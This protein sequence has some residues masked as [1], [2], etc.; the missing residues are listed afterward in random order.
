MHWQAGNRQKATDHPELKPQAA[1]SLALTGRRTPCT[2]SCL[3]IRTSPEEGTQ[4]G[5]DQHHEGL[6]EG[7]TLPAYSLHKGWPPA[8]SSCV[9]GPGARVPQIPAWPDAVSA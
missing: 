4:D 7:T 2:P 5:G 1:W 8:Y 3:E 9:A 6:L